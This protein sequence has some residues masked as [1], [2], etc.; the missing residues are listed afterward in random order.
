M[1][2]N[3][4]SEIVLNKIPEEYYN[5]KTAV[6]RSEITRCEKINTDIF[7]K[8]EEGAEHIARAIEAE[9]KFNARVRRA[10]QV[11]Q[12]TWAELCACGCVQRLRVFPP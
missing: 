10:Y 6:E 12:A 9:I 2:L 11:A 7:P 3:L 5:P 8:I 1:R 4:S